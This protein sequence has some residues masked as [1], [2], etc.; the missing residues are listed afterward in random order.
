MSLL[1]NCWTKY[2]NLSHRTDRREH[3][4]KE[5]AR[6]GIQAQRFEAIKTA[7]HPWTPWKTAVM[8]NRTPG[9]IGCWVSQ[10]HV[11]AEAFQMSMHCM[12]LE[13]DLIFATDFKERIDY[14]EK[15]LENKNWDICFLGGTVHINPSYW[16]SNGHKP[17]IQC[18]CTL[19]RD[20]ECTDDP[21]MIRVYGAFSTHAY[22]VNKDSIYKILTSLDSVIDHSIG[23]DAALIELAPT[24]NC[25]MMLPGAVKQYDNESSIGNGVTYFSGFSKLG[26]YWW[27]DNMNS[28]DPTSFDFGEAKNH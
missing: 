9:A 11:M 12:V 25:F 5:L 19:N 8:Q 7:D 23:I 3:M 24:L 28:F 2:I 27:S 17:E 14:I 10:T 22:I 1:D 15:F 16:H 18:N 20:A 21:R 4:E 13:D 6:V 26:K